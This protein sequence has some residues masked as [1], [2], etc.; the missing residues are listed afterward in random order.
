LLVGAL[1]ATLAVVTLLLCVPALATLL[2]HA[3]PSPLGFGVAALAFPAL[4]LADAAH[5]VW[6]RRAPRLSGT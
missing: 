3:L 2:G 1:L 5:K 6:G 4:L